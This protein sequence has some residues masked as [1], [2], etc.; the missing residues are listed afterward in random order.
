MRSRL[1]KYERGVNF[2][3]V[4]GFRRSGFRRERSVPEGLEGEALKV[5][6]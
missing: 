3:R 2:Q 4:G 5:G 1:E 6:A